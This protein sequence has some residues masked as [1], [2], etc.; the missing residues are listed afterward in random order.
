M[1]A[2]LDPRRTTGERI[3]GPRLPLLLMRMASL[4]VPPPLRRGWVRE[5]EGELK[6]RW[7]ECGRRGGRGA[8]T[9]LDLTLR[10]LGSFVDALSFDGGLWVM[11]GFLLDLKVAVR[12]LLRRPGFS[13]VVVSTLAVGVGANGAIF[14]LARDVLLRP[15]PYPDPDKVVA[16]EGYSEERPGLGG[17]VSYPNAWDLGEEATTMAGIAA[18][19]WWQGVL[20]AET[21]GIVLQGAI[22]TANF[23]QVLAV[24]PGL[25]RFFSQEEEGSGGSRAVVLSHGLWVEQFGG[26]PGVVGRTLTL[27]DAPYEVIGVTSADFEDPG[28]LGRPGAHPRLWRTVGSPPSRW[29]RDGRSWRA[30]GRIREGQA[31]EAARAELSAIMAGLA[32][33]FPEANAGRL[34]RLI[35]LRDRVAGPARMALFTLLGSVGIL[36]LAASL[37]LAN[38]L[39]GRAL[40]RQREFAVQRAMGAPRWRIIRRGSLEALVLAVV[41]GGLGTGLSLIL[42]RGLE[43]VGALFLPRPVS[44][45][46][47]GSVLLFMV[48]ITAGST[49]LFGLAPAV[50]AARVEEG[51]PGQDEGRGHTRGRRGQRL[52]RGLVVAGVSLTAVL[53]VVAG[54]LLRSFQE[55]GHVDLGFQTAGVMTIDLHYSA[56]RGLT[57]VEAA[58]QWDE[59]LTAARSVPGVR[60]A[61]AIDFVPLGPSYSCDEVSRAD[62]PAPGPGEGQCAETRSTLPGAL[63]A[64]GISLVRGRM[65]SDTDDLDAPPVVLV[66][67]SMARTHWPEEDPIG[68]TLRVHTQVHEVVGVVREI[69][70]FGA[71]MAQRPTVYIPTPQEGWSGPRRGLA[72]VVRGEGRASGLVGLVRRAV[73][74]VNPSIAF[75][76]VAT[77]RSLQDQSLAGPRFRAFL[78]G[79]FGM[80]GRVLAILGISGVMTCSVARRV[81]EMGVRMAVGADPSEVLGLIVREGVTLTVVGLTLGMAGAA[82]L[83]GFLDALLFEV[84]ARDPAVFVSAAVVVLCVGALSSYLPALRASRVN[85]VEALSFE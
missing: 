42:G 74:E 69:Q 14:G 52:Q 46:L 64:L 15:F 61:G 40:D 16:V 66:D 78:L 27:N 81:R 25:G 73:L 54:L 55:L 58:V 11:E 45:D 38:L 71:G 34:I 82:V 36:L 3:A 9:Y 63:E 60:Q 1:V 8:S 72:L 75:G 4:A 77:L 57:P 43:R 53:L 2:D 70:H 39:L 49:V 80:A 30:L 29:P 17:T 68:K 67:E 41:G 83:G 7:E 6:G 13:L 84:T 79:A 56:W 12:S 44:G 62:E 24:D 51:T 59:V 23:F 18:L 85:P 33:G 32:E 31:I 50:E 65:I 28:L 10:A 22:V 35:P 19:N 47:D 37:N 21:G 48:A 26:D 76:D 20:P 5:W